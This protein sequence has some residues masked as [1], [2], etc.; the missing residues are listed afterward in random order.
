MT[1]AQAPVL[2]AGLR[3]SEQFTVESRHT[4]PEIEPTWPGFQDMPPVLATAMMVAF[5]EQTCIMGLQPYLAPGQ[6]TVGIHVDVGHVAATPVGLKVTAEVELVEIDGRALL[7]KVSCRDDAGLI[8][9]GMHRRAII[10]VARFMQRLQ[11]KSAKTSGGTQTAGRPRL[12]IRTRD[13]DPRSGPAIEVGRL[14]R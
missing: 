12:A 7:F 4:V 10:D 1:T 9:E 5:I 11:E 8:G 13:Q 6:H 3:H 14:Q 2:A